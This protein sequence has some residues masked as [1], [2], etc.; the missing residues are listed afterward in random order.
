MKTAVKFIVVV[1]TAITV[2]YMIHSASLI[3]GVLSYKEGCNDAALKMGQEYG[4]E[5]EG[6]IGQFCHARVKM[7]KKELGVE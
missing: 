2:T 1:L 6:Y 5:F 7:I 4:P 3:F